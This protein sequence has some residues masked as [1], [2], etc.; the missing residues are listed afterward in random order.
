NGRPYRIFVD[1][2]IAPVPDWLRAALAGAAGKPAA[3]LPDVILEGER[4]ATL[5]SLAGSMRARGASRDAIYAAISAENES[6]CS[7]PLPD[8]DLQRIAGSVAKYQ[9]EPTAADEFEAVPGA[10]PPAATGNP[11]LRSEERRVGKECRSRW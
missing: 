8:E 11:R 5:V 10:E 6:R 1:A 3:V 4:E 2:P 9:P 7:P